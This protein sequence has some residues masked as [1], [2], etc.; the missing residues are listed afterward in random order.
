MSIRTI[1][2]IKSLHKEFNVPGD[3]SISHRSIILGAISNGTTKVSNFLDGADCKATIS[4]FR[5]MGVTITKEKDLVI[6]KGVGLTGLKK[7]T[8]TLETGNSG[9]TTRLLAGLLAGQNFTSIL[10]GDESLNQRPMNRVMIPLKEMNAQIESLKQNGCAPLKISPATLSGISYHSPV[11][12]AQVKSAILLAGLYAKESTTVIEPILSRN[13][14]ELMMEAFG[15]TLSSKLLEDGKTSVTLTPGNSLKAMDIHVP[16]DISS[17]AYLIA[18]G[19]LL[20]NSEIIVRNVGINPT[21]DGFLKVVK[22]MGGNITLLNKKIC[23][24]EATADI[25]VKSS[26]LKATTIEGSIIPTLIDEIPIIA[27]MASVATGTTS[28]NDA[29]ELAVKETNRIQT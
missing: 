1:K 14:T 3:K 27:V 11:A 23:A 29:S 25:L 4:C 18:A 19:L 28:I 17:A 13:H 22:D 10:S 7:P 24:G 12:S 9:T 16:G 8:R 15:V 21:R 5:E 6:I 26:K 20:P 2:P